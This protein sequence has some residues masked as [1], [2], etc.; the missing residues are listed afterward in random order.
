MRFFGGFKRVLAFSDTYGIRSFLMA[1]AFSLGFSA[2]DYRRGNILNGLV[3]CVKL[4][5]E[6]YGDRRSKDSVLPLKLYLPVLRSINFFCLG[7][8]SGLFI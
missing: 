3:K 2:L 1:R 4:L 6:N 5:P 8:E 7:Y